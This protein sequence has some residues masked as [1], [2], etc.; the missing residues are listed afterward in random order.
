M[1]AKIFIWFWG[2]IFL[3]MCAAVVTMNWL[4]DD[5][6][7]TASEHE[8]QLLLQLMAQERPN[9][10]EGRKLWRQINRGWNLVAVPV[11]LT[12]QL[13]FEFEH[14]ADQAE[15]QGNILYGQQEGWIIVGPLARDGYLYMGVRKAQWYNLFDAENKVLTLATMMSV[16]TLLCMLLAWSLTRPI[17]RLQQAVRQLAQGNFDTQPLQKMQKNPDEMGQ[18]A[19]EMVVMANSLQR[20]LHGHQQ[21]LRDV[22]HELRS[23]LT[24]LQIALAIARKKDQQQQLSAEHDRI[25][26]AVEQVNHLISQILDLARLQQN[27]KKALQTQRL[28][29]KQQLQMWMEDAELEL[30]PKHLSTQWCLPD[31]VVPLDCDWLLIERAFDNLLRN[32]IRYSPDQG[33]LQLGVELNNKHKPAMVSLWVQDQGPGVPD[34]QLDEIFNAFAQVDSARDHSSGGYGLGLALVKRIVELHGGTVV[35]TNQHPGLRVTLLLPQHQ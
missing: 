14:F 16:I 23:P 21:L 20:S 30:L 11:E 7:R 17:H 9:I 28:P 29:L 24:R 8:I 25:E 13:P 4:A 19:G 12:Y 32:A 35:A 2:A 18:L 5:Y 31:F 15:Q 1:F 22:S 6:T 27:D 26:R 10:A 34:D 3:S 33:E